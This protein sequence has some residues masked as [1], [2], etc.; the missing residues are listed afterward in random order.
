M[1]EHKLQ[2]LEFI[3]QTFK[4]SITAPPSAQ[5]VTAC[6]MGYFLSNGRQ[7]RMKPELCCQMSSEYVS[8]NQI[9]KTTTVQLHSW[10]ALKTPVGGN[11]P[12]GHELYM[13]H[14]LYM[15]RQ[16]A[17]IG[18]GLWAVVNDLMHW[19]RP[20]SD[21][22]RL[23]T[24]KSGEGVYVRQS[25]QHK[26]GKNDVVS[27]CQLALPVTISIPE[28]WGLCRTWGGNGGA[29]AGH[30]NRVSYPSSPS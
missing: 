10:V 2:L 1:Q 29:R 7:R 6:R 8:E 16:V 11:P 27:Y 21:N 14:P 13:D 19:S 22:E 30:R 15:E 5:P 23:G 12:S 28:Q 26:V 20:R 24:E 4:S 18:R 3:S 9:S 25:T 17:R